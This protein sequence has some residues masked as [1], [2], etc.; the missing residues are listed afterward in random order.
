MPVM[1]VPLALSLCT[2][3]L[4]LRRP[5]IPSCSLAL[6]AAPASLEEVPRSAPSGE[7]MALIA[8]PT[9]REL[10][11]FA[12]PLLF[13]G[14]T[15]PVLSL[16]DS[17]VVGRQS[18]LGL[19]MLAPAT[20]LCDLLT[21]IVQ[22]P[23]GAASTFFC[24]TAIACNDEDGERLSVRTGLS[25]AT[26]CGIA[27][28]LLLLGWC[29]PML[30]RLAGSDAVA[31]VPGAS[32]YVLVRAIGMPAAMC[33]VTLQ[34]AFLGAKDWRPP[35]VA[36]I[37]ACAANLI[38]DVVLVIG[39]KMGASHRCVAVVS[40]CCAWH[41]VLRSPCASCLDVLCSVCLLKPPGY[42]PPKCRP[43]R[44][45]PTQVP[46]IRV[47]PTPCAAHSACRPPK[48]HPSEC[49]PPKCHPLRVPPTWVPTHP[50]ATHSA[51]PKRSVRTLL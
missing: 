15:T 48:C 14:I 13:M 39:L 12:A 20:A 9:M 24:A 42:H 2:R 29:K 41:V 8:P 40:L 46:P 47:P 33:F 44:V 18:A 26:A 6:T 51:Y 3:P 45:P 32:A 10:A 11:L 16:V 35:V 22:V 17:A 34:G 37:V 27:L 30:Y 5:A 23:L 1:L 50:S 43:L 7:E 28:S 49:R 25:I 38:A 36:A 19:A 31:L 4:L 21:Y